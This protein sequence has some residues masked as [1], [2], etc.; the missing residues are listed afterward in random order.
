MPPKAP[1]TP[2][3][4]A[5]AKQLKAATKQPAHVV[6]PSETETSKSTGNK[7]ATRKRA[8]SSI[9]D[10]GRGKQKKLT[11]TSTGNKI[12]PPE[13]PNHTARPP[14]LRNSFDQPV[15][16]TPI[17]I[18]GN[19]ASESDLS[20]AN[21]SEF[22]SSHD[23]ELQSKK[24]KQL[25]DLFEDE[26]PHFVTNTKVVSK[27]VP[28]Q[29]NLKHS[30][31]TST[32]LTIYLDSSNLS[33]SYTTSMVPT[34]DSDDNQDVASVSNAAFLSNATS[35][36][37]T[38]A[39]T[40]KTEFNDVPITKKRAKRTVYKIAEIPHFT[41][42]PSTL[43]IADSL[44]GSTCLEDSWSLLTHLVWNG[45]NTISILSQQP[46]IQ[47]IIHAAIQLVE[48]ELVFKLLEAASSPEHKEVLQRLEQD[49]AYAKAFAKVPDGRIGLIRRKLKDISDCVVPG[50]YGVKMGDNDK[51][52]CL[53]NLMTFIY[54]FDTKGNPIFSQ[55]FDHPAV[56]TVCQLAFFTSQDQVG[57]KYKDQFVSVLDD[58]DE[59]EV[60]NSM[61][62]AV[63][64][65]IFSSLLDLKSVIDGG[66]ECGDFGQGLIGI[67]DNNME[68]LNGIYAK[69]PQVYHSLMARKYK[70]VR[71]VL[72]SYLCCMLLI[73][74]T[75]HSNVVDF[76]SAELKATFAQIDFDGMSIN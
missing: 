72:V 7:P 5:A 46:H 18:D 28:G 74:L 55:P 41:A 48:R 45:N 11:G 57:I 23:D 60:P 53:L 71:H 59:P 61:V 10:S 67:F 13:E 4:K 37:T 1:V 19:T 50:A 49:Q 73:T 42:T 62:S 12:V 69:S 30:M 9:A 43:S 51:I 35:S 56:N 15:D 66:R 3:E 76:A 16:S 38:K 32:N 17:I 63:V 33:G 64:T 75:F 68:M 47:V 27:P 58:N 26:T 65:A 24:P 2:G 44:T 54:K 21:D 6:S 29:Q 39:V 36:Q 31:K 8:A 70:A 40:I 20:N 14:R 34:S 52:N 22:L 25:K